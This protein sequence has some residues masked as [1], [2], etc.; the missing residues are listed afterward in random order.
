[1]RRPEKL[2]ETQIRHAAH[3]WGWSLDVYDSAVLIVAGK[4]IKKGGLQVGSPDMM[5]ASDSGIALYIEL[6]KPDHNNI[7]RIEQRLFLE[8]KI[9]S[10]AFGVVTDSPEHLL[11]TYRKWLSLRGDLKA[12]RDYLLSCLPKKVLVKGKVVSL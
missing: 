8:R 11:A 2:V 3:E 1:M 5:G 12:A 7:C 4:K 6:K 10:N 9:E